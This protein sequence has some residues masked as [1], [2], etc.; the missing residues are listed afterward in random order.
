MCRLKLEV[1]QRWLAGSS[2]P[3]VQAQYLDELLRVRATIAAA[4]EEAK[5]VEAANAEVSSADRED[6]L[7]QL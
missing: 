1:Q 3:A 6:A 5:R 7:C 2:T 4:L